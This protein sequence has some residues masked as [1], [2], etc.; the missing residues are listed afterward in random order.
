MEQ[1]IPKLGVH[2]LIVSKIDLFSPKQLEDLVKRI[3]KNEL[4][5]LEYFGGVIGAVMG[6][7]QILINAITY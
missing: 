2:G 7:V 3:C 6:I 4:K 5:A 1:A